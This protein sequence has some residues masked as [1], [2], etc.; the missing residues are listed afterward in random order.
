MMLD[1]VASDPQSAAG[2]FDV[3]GDG[4]FIYRTG[5]LP[6]VW[7]VLSLDGSGKTAPL[8]AKP[9]MYYT[10]RWS[11]DGRRLAIAID[12]G[13][14]SDIYVHDSQRGTMTRLTFTASSNAD[15]VW[16]P[17]G[18]H[19]IYRSRA[20]DKWVIWWIRADGAGEPIHLLDNAP[21]TTDLSAQSFLPD[22]RSFVFASPTHNDVFR[23]S[24]D[25]TDVDHPK[26]GAAERL[27]ST[28]A[29]EAQPAV[30]PDGKWLAYTSNESGIVDIYVRPLGAAAESTVRWQVSSR[31]GQ[32]PIWS[33]T[34]PELFFQANNRVMIVRYT[35]DG[36]S[37][38]PSAPRLWSSTP[39]LA[40]GF[41]NMDLA[42]DGKRFAIFSRPDPDHIET[43]LRMTFLLNFF[44]ELRRRAPGGS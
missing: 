35:T 12:D 21:T 3:S 19:L 26:P 14:G 42:P 10:P 23:M 24:L 31:G 20:G 13:R 29:N 40:P 11:P 30:S 4:V 18:E 22:G 41:I 28:P 36:R 32:I 25:L 16:A 2:R 37:F 1:D 8:L 39:L 34:A 43:A 17:D 33:K 7:P 6:L 44:D 5:R 38:V 9:A 27:F 15:P